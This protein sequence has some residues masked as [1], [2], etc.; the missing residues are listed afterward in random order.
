[1]LGTVLGHID[2]LLLFV[3]WCKT[4]G[5][6]VAVMERCRYELYQCGFVGF[7]LNA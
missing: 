6:V 5:G 7:K 1:M 4:R 3:R 2:A